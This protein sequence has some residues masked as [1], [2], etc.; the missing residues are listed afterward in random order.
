MFLQQ[1]GKRRFLYVQQPLQQGVTVI[2]ITKPERLKLVS[3]ASGEL[4][5]GEFRTRDL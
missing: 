5:H 3:Q 4:D 1:E 2:D